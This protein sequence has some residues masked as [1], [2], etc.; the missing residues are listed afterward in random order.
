MLWIR[1]VISIKAGAPSPSWLLLL[2]LYRYSQQKAIF[3]PWRHDSLQEA[4]KSCLS[5]EWWKHF[6]S[7]C[8]GSEPVETPWS[9][10]HFLPRWRKKTQQLPADTL[11][12]LRSLTDDF[13]DRNLSHFILPDQSV[14][15]NQMCVQ[16]AGWSCMF[17]VVLYRKGLMVRG[18]SKGSETLCSYFVLWQ[19]LESLKRH[20]QTR[21]NQIRTIKTEFSPE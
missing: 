5:P 11:K 14:W 21:D 10:S 4:V 6:R 20:V 15:W 12:H 1:P 8:L 7:L 13:T 3:G 16:R 19:V 2:Q 9:V 18:K 17:S